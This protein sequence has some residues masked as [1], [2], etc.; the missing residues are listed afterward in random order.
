M[1][2]T[3]VLPPTLCPSCGSRL[4]ACTHGCTKVPHP[5]GITICI[6]CAAV[7]MFDGE[8]KLKFPTLDDLMEA[9]TETIVKVALAQQAVLDKIHGQ[10]R[11]DNPAS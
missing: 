8:L 5:G 1:S 11:K 4:D 9:S 10:R 6:Y 3:T 7:L 2:I